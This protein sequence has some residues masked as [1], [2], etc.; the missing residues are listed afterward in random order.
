MLSFRGFLALYQKLRNFANIADKT[1]GKVGTSIVV[2]LKK[3]TTSGFGK[4]GQSPEHRS[5]IKNFARKS[6]QC[7]DSAWAHTPGAMPLV[8][9]VCR[10]LVHELLA[11]PSRTKKKYFLGL[12][13]T[14]ALQEVKTLQNMSEVSEVVHG[15]GRNSELG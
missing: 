15:L 1:R 8:E 3:D 4:T 10:Q 12:L 13:S 14:K 6:L 5:G 2:S 9:H 7:E 11:G